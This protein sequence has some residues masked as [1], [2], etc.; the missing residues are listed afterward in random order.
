[1]AK[2]ELKEVASDLSATVDKVDPEVLWPEVLEVQRL[3]PYLFPVAR[4]RIGYEAQPD[5]DVFRTEL[6]G[7][8]YQSILR[9][10]TTPPQ[11]LSVVTGEYELV[12]HHEALSLIF[13]ALR[14]LG[15]QC[16]IGQVGSNMSQGMLIV[17]VLL[18]AEEEVDIPHLGKIQFCLTVSNSYDTSRSFVFTVTARRL[19]CLNGMF[20]PLSAL[21]FSMRHSSGL[22]DKLK[23]VQ[24]AIYARAEMAPVLWEQFFSQLETLRGTPE[25]ILDA[26]FGEGELPAKWLEAAKE[27]T[28]Y[29]GMP[30]GL[31]SYNRI[32]DALSH[33]G[34]KLTTRLEYLRITGRRFLQLTE[35]RK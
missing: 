16:R 9:M 34:P 26:A 30:P 14:E 28:R 12:P 22:T 15:V 7:A 4:R 20:L 23:E 31:D 19:A 27:I 21:S 2:N 13:T 35:G 29:Q 6:P 8:R 32:T 25:E 10:D 24:E 18:E 3:R 11:V 33:G 1:M 5:T 17:E